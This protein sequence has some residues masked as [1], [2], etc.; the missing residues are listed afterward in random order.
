MFLKKE[1]ELDFA[2]QSC[3]NCCRYFNINLTHFDIERILE[4]R[5]DLKPKDFVAFSNEDVKE[6]LESFI[7]TSGKRQMTLK[8]KPGGKEC[9]FL[10]NNMCSIHDFKPRVCKVWPF[11]L[12]KGSITWIKEHRGFIKKLCKHTA[13]SG[14][15]DPEELIPLIKQHYKERKIF[16]KM[17]QKWNEDKKKELKDGEI[18]SDILDEHFLNF[19]LKEINIR[20]QVEG[21]TEKEEELLTGIMAGLV[22]D[23]RVE[24]ITEAQSANIYAI[25]RHPD[26]S[27]NLFIQENNLESFLGKNNLEKLR[28]ALEA[29]FYKLSNSP[30]NGRSCCFYIKGKVL[31]LYLYSFSDLQKPLPYDTRVLYNP[32]S[33]PVKLLPVDE[34]MQAELEEIYRRFWFKILEAHKYIKE[35]NFLDAWFLLGSAVNNELCPLIYWL[36]QKNF[37]LLDI[38]FLKNKTADLGDFLNSGL[39]YQS[40]PE[41][42]LSYL[43]KLADIFQRNWELCG[44]SVSEPFIG[45]IV[46]NFNNIS[47]GR[48][49]EK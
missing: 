38:P 30:Y 41:S 15:N 27:F 49:T 12:E 33:I 34:Q 25:D 46:E 9:I 45:K 35:E 22:G 14:A 16:S 13:V 20:K 4:N 21:E 31:N 42:Q 18:F 29:D 39:D 7:S 2:C 26:I 36:N 40:D 37:T 23:R 3:G 48:I 8:K 47:I 1:N 19:V 44:I 24:A 6:D 17:V 11:S 32:Y 5:P 10:V 28:E 43:K